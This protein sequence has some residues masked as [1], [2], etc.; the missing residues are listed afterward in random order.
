MNASEW[1]HVALSFD[2]GYAALYI[3]G[4]HIETF[5]TPYVDT[6]LTL[7]ATLA[8][9]GSSAPMTAVIDEFRIWNSALT[10]EEIRAY[11]NQPIANVAEAEAKHKLALYY[12]FNQNSGDVV[13]ATSNALTGTR[14]GFGPDGDSWSSSLGAFCLSNAQRTDVTADYLT[15]YR[16]PF[17]ATEEVMNPAA[18]QYV[19]LLTETAES[20]WVMLGAGIAGDVTTGL[21]VDTENGNRLALQTKVDNFAGSV[22]DHRIYQTVT[23]PAGHYVFGVESDDA[24]HDTESYVVAAAGTGLPTTESLKNAAL[25]YADLGTMETSFSLYKETAVSLGLLMNTRGERNLYFDRFYLEKKE[26]NDDFTWTGIDTPADAVD[27]LSITPVDGGVVITA[28]HPVSVKVYTL[29]GIEAYAGVVSGT[30]RIMLPAGL[31][32]VGGEKFIVK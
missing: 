12:Q 8:L 19:G 4:R 27:N 7:P 20:A 31:Y 18:P 2:K 25:G 14:N 11:A 21:S 10:G 1:H 15:N 32:I 26:T 5:E 23:L 29:A 9:G 24:D 6:D 17:L 30:K 22:S 13:D 28:A 3:D 16:K